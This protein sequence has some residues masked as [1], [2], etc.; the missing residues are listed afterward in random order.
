[1]KILHI[2]SVYKNK[3]SGLSFSIPNLIKAQNFKDGNAELFNLSEDNKIT[4]SLLSKYRTIAIHSYFSIKHL[5]ILLKFPENTSLIICPRG[6]FSKSNHYSL[7]K[8]VYSF[9]Y[10]KILKWKR[11]NYKFHFL[12]QNEKNRSRFSTNNDFV[13]GNCI[14]IEELVEPNYEVKFNNKKIV[15]IGRFS[16]HI[17]GLD[18]LMELLIQNKSK[19]DKSGFTFDFYGPDSPD[20]QHL[21]KLIEQKGIK[22][23]SFFP[24]IFNKEKEEIMHNASFHILNSRSEGFPVS[25]LE[26]LSLGTPQLL[27]QGT[28]LLED[29]IDDSFGY[30][31]NAEMFNKLISLNLNSYIELC[32]NSYNYAKR[33]DL[34]VVGKQSLI[35]YLE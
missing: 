8:K 34:E 14:K 18:L 33:F 30:E 13:I 2:G 24:P 19:I 9:V 22:F 28:N 31:V 17:K 16:L 6:A 5:E 7:K 21:Q 32:N 23:V 11:I 35:E 20:K 1:M 26:S 27:S 12:T 15:Y 29:L 3:A 25:V 4:K 10:F